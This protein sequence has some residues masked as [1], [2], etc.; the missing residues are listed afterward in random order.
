MNNIK[1][2]WKNAIGY[3][4]YIKSFFDSNNDGIGNLNGITQK[5]NYIKDLG[6][7]FIWICPFY[8]SPMDDNGYDIRN[9]YK[10]DKIYGTNDDLEKLI[11]T[12]HSLNIRVI[13]DLVLNHTSDE[14]DWFI[15]SENKIEPY[16][17]FYIW[18][19]GKIIDNKLFPPNNW[20]SFFSGSTWKYSE[21][22][23][24]YYLKLFSN[25]MPDINYENKLVFDEIEK[26]INYYSSLNI[27]GFR[28]D[29]IS[30]IGK[31][32]SFKNAKNAKKSYKHFS[33]LPKTH[34]YLKNLNKIFKKY[35]LVTMGELGGKPSKNEL[36]KYTTQG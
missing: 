16:S 4:I 27:D 6:I 12:A 1:N 32:L 28:V 31:D 21:K 5:L 9:Y 18:R 14:H 35:N 11:E 20:E 19:D 29:A 22:R 2:W 23:K 25:K 34:F 15:K 36:I 3:Q 24:Q 13:I 17:D 10:V 30:H 7:D 33:N 8:D 26:I